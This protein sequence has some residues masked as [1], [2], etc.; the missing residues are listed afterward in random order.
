MARANQDLLEAPDGARVLPVLIH[1]EAAFAGQGVV[2]ETLNLSQ[3]PGYHTGGTVHVIVNNQL[4][5]TTPSEH[6][7][8]SMYASDVAKMVQAP[9]LHVNG[10]D[11]EACVRAARLAFAFRQEFRKDVIVDLWCY[12]RWGHNEADEPSFTQPL[13]Y[14][15]IGE[16]RSV[17]KRYM[18]ALVD[19]G[20]LSVEEAER[21]L[22]AFSDRL[23]QAYDETR[24]QHPG[25]PK[26][27][28]R[29][30]EPVPAAPLETGVPRDRLVDVAE[31]LTRV[32]QRF[33]LHPKLKRGLEQRRASLDEDRVDWAFAEALAVGSLLL[34]GVTVRLTGQDSRRG[35]FSQRHA[36]LVDQRTGEEYLPFQHLA[37]RQGRAFIYDSLLSEFAAL[38][39]EYGYS[40]ADPDALVL[41]EAQFGDF[42][43]GAQV[44]V[45]GY[46]VAAEDR[47]AQ[48]S[49]L[50]LLL[51]HGYEGQGPEHS[52]ARLERFLDLAADDNIEVTVPSTAAQYFHLLRR[53]ALRD[54]RKPLVILTPKSLL[55]LPAAASRTTELESGH[56]SSV[57][58]DPSP[59]AVASRVL[60]CHGKI[61]YELAD[62]RAES[63]L[64]DVAL[65]RLE[66]CYPFPAEALR[67][68]LGRF[69]GAEIVWVQEE[70]ENM[71]AARF[72]LRHLRN[73][74]GVEARLVSRPESPSPATGSLTLHRMEQLDLIDRA[75]ARQGG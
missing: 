32:P 12:R 60:L 70:P 26:V 17:R 33:E 4:G 20:E 55:R 5:F 66:E 44:I 68:E 13:M 29:G 23:R 64:G 37:D 62:R 58:P 48:T 1:G 73:R 74:L 71:G 75:F 72:I 57:L 61:F 43:N 3:L 30:P 7:R 69:A 11:P 28:R 47:W 52:S 9:I 15:R 63:K 25:V 51:P 10:D 40:V 19:R 59:P 56:F 2:A 8:S 38:G 67:E 39:F 14:R 21:A 54:V 49:G 36:V 45:D 24:E 35:T 65:V 34:D 50:V 41:W 31:S 22:E 42:A 46:V 53:Q 6:G 18:E 16:L 27:E